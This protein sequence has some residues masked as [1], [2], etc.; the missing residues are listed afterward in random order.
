MGGDATGS[1]EGTGYRVPGTSGYLLLG[2]LSVPSLRISYNAPVILTFALAATAVTLLAPTAWFVAWPDLA[3]WRTY[4]GLITHV[5]GHASWSH[6]VGNL[7]MILLIGPILEERDGSTAML[8]RIVATALATGLANLLFS[9]H[10]LLGASGV[11][12]MLILLASTANLRKGEIPLTF[13]LVAMLF[14]GRE[15][16]DA[17]GEDDV[18]QL[19]HLIGGAA[20]AAFGF[21]APGRRRR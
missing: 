13:L 14:L 1:G 19:A 9:D 11:V 21:L 10:A 4:P 6:L 3:G 17:F 12:F 20:G 15:L 5:L 16:V 2:Y 18:S 8:L 7:T